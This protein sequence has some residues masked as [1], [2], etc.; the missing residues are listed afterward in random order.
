MARKC[1]KGVICTDRNTIW[2]TIIV[3]VAVGVAAWFYRSAPSLRQGFTSDVPS[4]ISSLSPPSSQPPIV[5]IQSPPIPTTYH[6]QIRPDIYPEPVQ[7]L[8]VGIPSLATRGPTG[9][10]EQ[11]GLLAAEGGSSGSAAPDRTLLPLYGR[12]ID[13]RRGKWNYYT[14]TDGMNPIQVPIRYR[15]RICDDDT[16][17]CD[18]ISSDD[19]IHVPALGRSFKAS[20]YRKSIFG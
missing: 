12:E 9:R 19:S 13:S 16:N 6:Q 8:G 15:N 4:P 3:L 1:P 14:R 20:V 2:L 5:V 11:V 7:R 17:G 10:Y 18:E